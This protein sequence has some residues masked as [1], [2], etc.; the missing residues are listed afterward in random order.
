VPDAPDGRPLRI[1]LFTYSTRPRGGV[2]H[3]LQLAEALVSLGHHV[4]LFALEKP[5]RRGFFRPTSVPSTFIP[6]AEEPDESVDDRIPRYIEAY[7]RFLRK[8]LASGDGFDVYHAED[9][10][11]GNALVHLRDEGLVPAVVRTVHHVD[12]FRSPGLISCQ[13]DS[14]RR[15]DLVL[16][17]SRWWQRR[18]GEDF[19]IEAPVVHNGVDLERHMPPADAAARDA[20][21][22]RLGIE[23][24]F[25]VLAVG[26]VEPRKNSLV[27]LRAF[28]GAYS[29]LSAAAGGL[30]PVLVV[31]GGETLFDYREYR[32]AYHRELAE[33]LAAGE[34]PADSVHIVGPVE[35]EDI[36]AWY[37]AA[38]VLA[39]PS[40]A[41]GWGLV[42]LEA[43]ASGT[44]V[45]ASD[46]EVLHEYLVD[47]D[48]AL[49]VPPSDAPALGR[50]VV[51]VAADRALATRLRLSGFA[52][53][54]RYGWRSSA[55]R[56]VEIYREMV[57]R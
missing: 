7:E 18:L 50:A 49:L 37:R 3:S 53:A 16:V 10:V 35:D 44:P 38:D 24:R 31:V 21:R 47:G 34:L 33:L 54:A 39:F 41:E 23:A 55:E 29:Q 8:S 28:A 11:S 6:V 43:Q 36:L 19:G 1:G 14:I 20:D 40:V 4:E 13:L 26:G 57:G 12:D 17:V 32:S 15:P 27:L 25:A 9:C 45:V 30:R 5:G 42:V 2:V 46:I 22:H 51:R 56:H 48:N 52:T